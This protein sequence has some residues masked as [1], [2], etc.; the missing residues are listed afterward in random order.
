MNVRLP[1]NHRRVDGGSPDAPLDRF[2]VFGIVLGMNALLTIGLLYLTRW[3]WER[4]RR[5][6]KRKLE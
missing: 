3:W 5:K 1:R 2:N 6:G 4:A